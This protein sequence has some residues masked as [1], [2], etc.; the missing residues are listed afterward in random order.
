M[1]YKLE[2]LKEII[3]L[4]TKSYPKITD[5]SESELLLKVGVAPVTAHIEKLSLMGLIKDA[6]PIFGKEGGMWI[7]FS[8]TDEGYECANDKE[9]F[10]EHISKLTEKPT[11]EISNSVRSLIDL[12]KNSNINPNYKD[13]FIATLNEIATCF[14]NE[15]YIATISLSGKILEIT[16]TEII[17]RNNIEIGD[18]VMLGQLIRKIKDSEIN[19]YL[20]PALPEISKVI[21]YSRNSAI[22]YNEKIPIPSREQAIMVIFAMKDIVQRNLSKNNASA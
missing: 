8:L 9:K 10:N 12:S 3:K 16:L 21:S 7:G 1:E 15:C 17:R 2:I 11:N 20:D 18:R 5:P 22:H 4:G 19:E 14:D 13:D 6:S